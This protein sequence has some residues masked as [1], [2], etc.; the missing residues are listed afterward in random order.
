LNDRNFVA[1]HDF[2]LG[3]G[4]PEVRTA[5]GRRLLALDASLPTI[6]NQSSF[7]S[8]HASIGQGVVLLGFNAVNHQAQVQNF[9]VLDWNATVGHHSVVGEGAFLG[10]GVQ[11]TGHCQL[12]AKVYLGAGSRTVPKVEVG[13]GTLV[14]AGSTVTKSLPELVMAVGTPA[15]VKRTLATTCSADEPCR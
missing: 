8:P 1:Q 5:Y 13:K 10:P 15:V 2:A 6:I 4:D 11:V 12:G 3:I 9:A 14:G 7:V